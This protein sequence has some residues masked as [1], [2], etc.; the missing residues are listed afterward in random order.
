[1]IFDELEVAHAEGLG[2]TIARD[3]E[4]FAAPHGKEESQKDQLVKDRL[5]VEDGL[6]LYHLGDEGERDRF[7][8]FGGRVV[9]SVAPLLT[10]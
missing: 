9:G 7:L 4:I 2:A 3:Q 10:L 6:A 5:T 8:V 1:M